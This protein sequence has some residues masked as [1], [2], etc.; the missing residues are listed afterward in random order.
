[1]SGK[2]TLLKSF[3]LLAYLSRIGF[4]VPAESASLPFYESIFVMI[5]H[6]DDL[7][8]G[9]SHFM[10]EIMNLKQVLLQAKNGGTCLAIFDEL[11]KG[12]NIEDAVKISTATLS[13]INQYANTL[14]FISTHLQQLA[15]MD[16][17]HQQKINTVYLDCNIVDNFPVFNFKLK[18]GWSQQKVGQLLFE[19]EGLFE[20]L[21]PK[22][23][24]NSIN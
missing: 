23:Q 17:N 18:E 22:S 20:L 7:Q 15:E 12:T 9:Y 13:G 5:S 1:M 2:S 4:S 10:S 8:S 11:F 19:K 3:G 16:I 21:K 14:F 6:N 24:S